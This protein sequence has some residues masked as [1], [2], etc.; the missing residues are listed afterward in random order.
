MPGHTFFS[1]PRPTL[2]PHHGTESEPRFFVGCAP[3]ITRA[4]H[5]ITCVALSTDTAALCVLLIQNCFLDIR[6]K[7]TLPQQY[8]TNSTKHVTGTPLHSLYSYTRRS[9]VQAVR[10]HVIA[11]P[12]AM[13]TSCLSKM[14]PF[15][16]TARDCQEFTSRWQ[17]LTTDWL[18]QVRWVG[19]AV[20]VCVSVWGSKQRIAVINQTLLM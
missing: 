10:T 19:C 17:W 5:V 20:L 14:H 12:R 11:F 18:M 2:H 7:T 6:V 15:H 1:W 16:T 4:R 8:H 3:F 9:S 13:L